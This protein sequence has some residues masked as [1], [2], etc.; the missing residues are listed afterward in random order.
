MTQEMIQKIV[1]NFPFQIVGD[2]VAI[3]PLEEAHEGKIQVARAKQRRPEKAIVVSVGD[4]RYLADGTQVRPPVEVGKEILYNRNLITL[5]HKEGDQT[6]LIISST[7][8]Y[9]QRK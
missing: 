5:E 6:Y 1:S 3:V 7:A 9:G 8:I 4:G 2:Y